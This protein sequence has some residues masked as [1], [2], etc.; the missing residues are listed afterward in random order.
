MENKIFNT[1]F[2][3]KQ[4]ECFHALEFSKLSEVL[5]GG[6]KGGGKSNLLVKWIY[7]KAKSLIKFWDLKKSDTPTIIG[8]LGRKRSSDLL[9]TTMETWKK[10]IP[11]SE[12]KINEQKKL[13]TINGAVSILYG[14]FDDRETVNKFNSMELAF[15]G[16]DQAE[17][18]DRAEIGSI[19]G[20]LRLKIGGKQPDYKLML[21]CN[22]PITDEPDFL[23]IKNEF[24]DNPSETKK[25]FKFLWKDNPHIASNYEQTLNDA[26]G[27]NPDLLAAYKDGE[28]DKIGAANLTIPRKLIEGLVGWDIATVDEKEVKRVTAADISEEGGKDETV[29]YDFQNGKAIG[30]EM[31]FHRDLMDTVGRLV[32]HQKKYRTNLISV[33]CVG[34]GAGVASRLQEIYAEDKYVKVHKFDSRITPPEGVFS[35][36]YHNYRAYAYF[37]ASRFLFKESKVCVPDDKILINQL[38]SIPWKFHSDG[39]IILLSKKEIEAKYGWS[40][41]RAD[42]FIIGLDALDY[43]KPIIV[44]QD[45][46][47]SGDF[48]VNPHFTEAGLKRESRDLVTI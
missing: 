18:L 42:A 47:Y 26:Y 13:I 8:F 33:D 40:P 32:A 37:K 48:Y 22:P 20:T 3:L 12:Y 19:R 43:A 36:T 38:A 9:V 46:N 16:V 27:F 25:F 28:W 21:T 45:E 24:I 15:A 41:D 35:D 5:G 44:S 1:N 14:G 11:P 4:F 17:E 7:Y 30:Q 39:R 34:D 2:T 31:Y 6:G 10:E 29:I 23:W